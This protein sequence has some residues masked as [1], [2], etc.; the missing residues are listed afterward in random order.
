MKT[1]KSFSLEDLDKKARYRL[2]TQGVIPRPIAFVTTL[3]A[4]G[5]LNGAPFS[6]FNLVS[7][8]PPLIMISVSRRNHMMKDTAKHIVRSKKFVVN[9]VNQAMVEA[10]NDASAPY[11]EAVSEIERVGLSPVVSKTTHV[12]GV[13]EA[14]VRFE[15]RLYQHTRIISNGEET[16]DLI[17]GE[18]EHMV[19]D[20]SLLDEHDDMHEAYNPVARLGGKTY[21]TLGPRFSLT[22]PTLKG[23][24]D[25]T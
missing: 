22:R 25:G 18:I 5:V 20:R 23:D 15:C 14:S 8:E 6:Y 4:D 13:A 24:K 16:G 7:V 12:P 19:V 2:L 11:D 3:S 17:I 1:F 10:V 21:A 9:M